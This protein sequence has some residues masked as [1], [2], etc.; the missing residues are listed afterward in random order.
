MY[1][2][3]SQTN[4][5]VNII[6]YILR[7]NLRDDVK[8]TEKKRQNIIDAAIIEFRGQGFLGAKTTAIA[9]RAGVS[10]RTLYKHFESKEA[11]FDAISEIMI[12]RNSV[13][14]SV[15]YDPDRDL[16]DQLVEALNKYVA[17]ITEPEAIGLTR[18]V[19]AELLRDL[20]RSR[21]FFAEF[22]THDYPIT[23]LIG[24]AMEA[25]ALRNVDPEFATAQL[26]GLVKSFFFWP[27]FLL[28]EEQD[29]DGIMEDCVAMFL[30]HYKA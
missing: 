1:L 22:E 20:D 30:A 29:L 10:S 15:A 16:V 26:L 19:I 13:M 28:G 11:L 2:H 21:H 7:L 27:E 3:L 6:F 8:L 23:K 18:M 4:E 5:K 17:V 14:A 12:A 24:G 9:K 25:G